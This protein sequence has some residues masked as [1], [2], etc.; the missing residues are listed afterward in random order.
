MFKQY[1][2]QKMSFDAEA[3]MQ[4]QQQEMAIQQQ[5]AAAVAQTAAVPPQGAMF[6]MP[7]SS[8]NPSSMSQPPIAGMMMADPRTET[9]R[10]LPFPMMGALPQVPPQQMFA[11]QGR[12]GSYAAPATYMGGAPQTY[13]PQ[14]A[15]QAA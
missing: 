12:P 7:P 10:S 6:S 1:E 15:P 13:T 11:E 2:L 3:K 9:V 14:L 4:R 8:F 5:Q